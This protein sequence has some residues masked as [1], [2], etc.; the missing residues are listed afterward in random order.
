[1]ENSEEFSNP[2]FVHEQLYDIEV[3]NVLTSDNEELLIGNDL[4]D[5]FPPCSEKYLKQLITMA[6]LAAD[7]QRMGQEDFLTILSKLEHHLSQ[8]CLLRS[9]VEQA[10][11]ECK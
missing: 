6:K 10:L 9:S 11:K 4:A 1:M 5:Q 7:T 8:E 3:K 2:D